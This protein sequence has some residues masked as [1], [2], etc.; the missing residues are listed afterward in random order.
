MATKPGRVLV[1]DKGMNAAMARQKAM[2][3]V[4]ATVG[5]QGAGARKKHGKIDNI[6]LAVVHEFGANIRHPGG[7][8]YTVSSM[9]GSSRSG[10]MVGGGRVTWLPKGSPDAIGVT[11]AH[12]IRIPERSFLRS[13]F[14]K[15]ALTYAGLLQKQVG[16]VIDGDAT[17]EQAVGIV[18]EKYLA[19][20]RNAIN[21]GIPP[22][23]ARSTVRR[24][25]SSKQLIDTSQLK[26]S[27]TV[28]VSKR[29]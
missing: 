28:K 14:D 6:G 2:R 1:I 22:K 21:A 19:D 8:P 16:R 11:R 18:G 7:T 4:T 27:I 10:G 9:G 29:R 12:M 15:N 3:G 13:T 24:K 23:L 17:P 5:V 20:I 25:G 26:Q